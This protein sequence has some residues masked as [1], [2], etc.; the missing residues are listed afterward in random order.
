MSPRDRAILALH[1][2]DGMPMQQVAAVLGVPLFTAYTRLRRARLR[3]ARTV[4]EI[5]S[6]GQ[7][8]EEALT[9]PALLTLERRPLPTS[10]ASAERGRK[11][12]WAMLP[13]VQSWQPSAPGPAPFPRPPLALGGIVAGAALVLVAGGLIGGRHPRSGIGPTRASVADRS[14][15]R[16]E[17]AKV[18]ASLGDGL[19]GY[20]RFD[21]QRDSPVV[22]D[23]SGRGQ[24]CVLTATAPDRAWVPGVHEDALDL[25]DGWLAC[26]RT[27]LPAPAGPAISVAA[28]VRMGG[29]RGQR[30]IVGR[31]LGSGTGDEFLLSL[32]FGH[33]KVRST[34]WKSSVSGK[35]PIPVG[36]WVHLAFTHD[37]GGETRLYQDG[38][39]VGR[40]QAEVVRGQPA[41]TNPITIGIDANGRDG[42]VRAQP[43]GGA[44]D[45]VVIYDRALG[46]EE[47]AALARG[48]RPPA[49]D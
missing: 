4:Q 29:L 9:A 47:I 20:W 14:P 25:R 34:L 31:Q 11:L 2:I 22:R 19:A 12:A 8:S 3:F 42:E 37:A 30:A 1:E 36:R 17:A 6:R 28:W 7:R 32:M 23:R 40:V 10:S 49:R 48:A 13:T 21:D 35:Q 39:E 16:A 26:P 38:S 18:L 15:A 33:P 44:V 43:L 46:P 45:E 24:A 41:S 5:Q 27:T